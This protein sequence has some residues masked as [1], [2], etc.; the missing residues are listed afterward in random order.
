MAIHSF[1]INQALKDLKFNLY[2]V[3]KDY[4]PLESTE[5]KEAKEYSSQQQIEISSENAINIEHN[6]IALFFFII[7]VEN[8]IILFLLV[9][10]YK[11]LFISRMLS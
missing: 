11:I 10:D 4:L 2:N 7:L 1:I 5:D 3:D 6:F 9:F 8:P